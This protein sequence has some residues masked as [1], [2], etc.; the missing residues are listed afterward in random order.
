MRT[1]ETRFG[2]TENGQTPRRFGLIDYSSVSSSVDVGVCLS[3]IR[4]VMRK[5]RDAVAGKVTW[6]TSAKVDS[7][8][9]ARSR[10]RRSGFFRARSRERSVSI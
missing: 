10:E 7:L 4:V 5:Q 8:L 3:F 2:L 9:V 1:L 6:M